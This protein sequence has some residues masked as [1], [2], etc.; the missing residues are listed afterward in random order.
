V[1][2]LIAESRSKD[3]ARNV[4]VVTI[5]ALSG[6]LVMGSWR[7]VTRTRVWHDNERLFTQTVVDAPQSYRAHYMLGAWFFETGRKR[8]GEHE[9]R[10]ALALFPYDPFMAYNLAMQ[11]QTSGMYGAAIPLYR[12][13][14]SIAPRFRQGEGRQNL[15]F[16]LAN[17]NEPASAREQALLAMSFGGARL[18]D[19]RRIVQFSD[20]VMGKTPN[21]RAKRPVSRVV[22]SRDGNGKVLH[23]SQIAGV[24]GVSGR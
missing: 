1:S 24:V 14:F 6:I 8:E 7:S 16:C 9:Y 23:Q 10:R 3:A 13:A 12:W 5:A 18:R 11:Y 17:A 4:R 15:A 20:S 22:S 2:A 21:G 19:L